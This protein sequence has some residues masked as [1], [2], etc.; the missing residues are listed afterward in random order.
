MQYLLPK[1]LPDFSQ[2]AI[3]VIGD[4]MMDR[5]WFG[6]ACRVSPEAPVP[7][8]N[9]N[10]T[11]DRPGGAG[12]VALNIS[13]L[14]GQAILLGITGNDEAA[15]LLA[16][17]LS[18]ANVQHDFCRVDSLSTIIKLRV[19]SRRQ[20]L[21]RLDFEK[22]LSANDETLIKRYKQYLK[23]VNLVALSDY[24]KGTLANPQLLIQLAR[25]ANVPVLV[26]PKGADFSIYKHANF[27][28]PNFK[29]FEAIVGPCNSEQEIIE[30]GRALLSN[31]QIDA[32]LVTRGEDGMTL[33]DQQDS[34]HLP[35]YARE[36]VDVTGAGDT[37]IAVLGTAVAAGASLPIAAALA[38]LA[39]ALAVSKVGAAT[40]STPELQV[41]L[42]NS[43]NF[44]T[45]IVNEEQL[46]QAVKQAK[47][48]GKKIVFTNGCFDILHA[49]HVLCLQMAKQLGDYLIVAV[50]T[51]ESVQ[52][53]KGPSRPI[54]HLQHRMI[55]LAGLGVVDWVVPFNDNTPERLLHLIQP[56]LLV[57]G[58]EYQLHEV[59]GA[60][61]VRAY[62]G[63][64]RLLGDKISS[65]TSI[66][67]RMAD[68][69]TA[70]VDMAVGDD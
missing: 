40:V 1:T 20:Q 29:E 15:N 63:E 11:D 56:D 34:T 58:G 68:A 64:V 44:T 13:A 3:L 50:N 60:D 69:T 35:A 36:V 2:A 67:N 31:Y 27:I 42:S 61:I 43:T 47:A 21:L 37:V 7:I 10:N 59:V 33:I 14:G 9:I 24:N 28:T 38:N 19:I 41:S 23:Q 66:I 55:V 51:D 5:Y 46:I 54:N 52:K 65:S 49:G 30:K 70:P 8:V 25:Q 53:L 48:Q 22:K 18:A 57:K 17:Q 4:I 16:E 45:G 32:L 26:D 12:N 62:G 6:D 39:A